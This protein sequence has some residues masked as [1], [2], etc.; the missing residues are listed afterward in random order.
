MMSYII[1]HWFTSL[2]L[3][4]SIVAGIFA[5]FVVDGWGALG[6]IAIS[7]VLFIIFIFSLVASYIKEMFDFKLKFWQDLIL[8]GIISAI[9]W[10]I[11][12]IIF[13]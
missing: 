10:L 6:Y 11:F 13:I 2:T 3:L 8:F 12:R 1:R 7:V 4:L 5:I 9:G